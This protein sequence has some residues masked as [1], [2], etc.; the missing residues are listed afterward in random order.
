MTMCVMCQM[1]LPSSC[2]GESCEQTE[3]ISETTL[4]QAVILS[5]TQLRNVITDGINEDTDSE[6]GDLRRGSRS[7]SERQRSGKS[8]SQS[9]GRKEAARKYPLNPTGPCEW[10]G[11][12]NCGGHTY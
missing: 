3:Q 11:Y 12:A 1:G 2:L 10:Q 8:E 7:R 9:A 6:D 5:P 4:S